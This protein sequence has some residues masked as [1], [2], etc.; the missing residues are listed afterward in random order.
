MKEETD[1]NTI[2][3]GEFNI[4]G[5]I[6]QTKKIHK[7]TVAI[8]DTLQQ[9]GLIGIKQMSITEQKQTHR[10]RGQTSGC[11]WGEQCG[12]GQEQ[13]MGLRGINCCV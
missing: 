1:E 9:F 12:E 8:N 3:V 4:N 13:G 6:I 5:Q 11:Q 10:Y 2:I 7:E